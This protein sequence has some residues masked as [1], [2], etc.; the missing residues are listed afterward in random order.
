MVPMCPLYRGSTVF[1]AQCKI[2]AL[3][4]PATHAT[5]K[6]VLFTSITS[7]S[8]MDGNVIGAD[9]SKQ[10]IQVTVSITLGT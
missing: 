1:M 6:S 10:L 3:S 2:R 7:I 5:T 8:C 4:A 9:V